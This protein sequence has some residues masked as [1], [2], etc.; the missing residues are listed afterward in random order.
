MSSVS[1]IG[2][3]SS[4]K[5]RRPNL[6]EEV[7]NR[8]R[9][10]IVSAELP[11]GV[12][13]NEVH[14]AA[15]LGV[16]RTPLREALS[17]LTSEGATEVIPRRGFFVRPLTMEEFYDV[18]DMRPLLDPVALRRAGIPGA[19]QLAKLK[20]INEKLRRA[21]NVEQAI[22][23]DD[24]WHL[25]LVSGCPNRELVRL[26]HE[27]MQRTKRYEMAL[28]GQP[29]HVKTACR[30]H[31]SILSALRRKDLERAC[32]LLKRNMQEGKGPIEAWLKKRL[33]ESTTRTKR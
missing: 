6:S 22:R 32:S 12:R 13:I 30:T 21:R 1:D 17:R 5:L 10:M 11:A 3:R 25:L 23:I 19:D 8:I 18:Y 33:S 24:E 20:S 14:L 2:S 28:M 15:Q 31:Q 26:I 16:S 27:Y 4:T 7:T 29:V 9:E